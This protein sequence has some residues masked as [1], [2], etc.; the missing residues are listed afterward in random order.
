M[1]EQLKDILFEGIF[2][3]IIFTIGMIIF[4]I[5]SD[6]LPLQHGSIQGTIML[7][8]YTLIIIFTFAWV[9]MYIW[10]ERT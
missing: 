7:Y 3:V 6:Y 9:S 8:Y 10:S 1:S 2:F 4:N 5:L